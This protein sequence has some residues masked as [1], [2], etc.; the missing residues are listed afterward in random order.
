MRCVEKH[1]PLE[2]N[3]V[4]VLGWG[5]Q[6]GVNLELGANDAEK[7]WSEDGPVCG[8]RLACT[9]K[10]PARNTYSEVRLRIN[11]PYQDLRSTCLS[12]RQRDRL[13]F[14]EEQAGR[15]VEPKDGDRRRLHLPQ[16]TGLLE[17]RPSVV[18]HPIRPIHH[19]LPPSQEEDRQVSLHS[20]AQH[21]QREG[22]RLPNH[23][24][25]TQE[26]G[27]LREGVVGMN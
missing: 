12:W 10:L 21:K 14:V 6:E 15:A 22:V 24:D 1:V 19:H 5:G 17:V 7:E 25:Q 23:Q 2:V 3:L 16:S 26:G 27:L 13:Q 18:H 20:I 4:E 8:R 11:P 9:H